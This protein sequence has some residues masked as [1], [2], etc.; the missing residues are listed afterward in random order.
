MTAHISWPMDVRLSH[1]HVNDDES[2]RATGLNCILGFQSGA[3]LVGQSNENGENRSAKTV[4][5]LWLH[6]STYRARRPYHITVSV[7]K[8]SSAVPQF[9]RY[10]F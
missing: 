6:P 5:L 9:T 2:R 1:Y 4:I 10:E 8:M 7:K 3:L